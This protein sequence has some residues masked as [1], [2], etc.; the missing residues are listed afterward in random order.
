MTHDGM[1]GINA[2]EQLECR[3]FERLMSFFDELEVKY[4]V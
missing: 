1:K 3:N 4:H 2:V